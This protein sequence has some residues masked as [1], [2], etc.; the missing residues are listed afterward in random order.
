[1]GKKERILKLIIENDGLTYT[2]IISKYNKEYSPDTV[3][4]KSGYSYLKRLKKDGLIENDKGINVL[5]MP[6]IKSLVDKPDNTE[7][8][9]DN[10]VLLMIEA[11]IDSKEYG[12]DISEKKIQLSL[13]RLRESDKIG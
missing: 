13:K 2:K 7:K 6:T 12:I 5:Y 4:K 10:L 11:E 9:T 1:M 3:K 8:T